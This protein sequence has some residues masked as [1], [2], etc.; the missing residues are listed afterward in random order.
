MSLATVRKIKSLMEDKNLK[1]KDI[2][3]FLNEP[4]GTVAK[5]LSENEK[6]RHEI[7]LSILIKLAPHLNAT[8][9]F[10]LGV[11]SSLSAIGTMTTKTIPLIGIAS[12]GIPDMVYNDDIQYIP[13]SEDIARDGVYAVTAE[14]DSMLSKIT[15]GDIVICDKEML[16]ESGNI[17]HYT[18]VDGESGIKKYSCDPE[19]E[20]VTLMPLNSD[21]TPVIKHSKDVKCARCF[22][23]MSD[24]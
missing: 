1:Q 21:Y 18:T 22:K 13:V 15:N 11:K 24:L 2:V 3:E 23:I 14:G 12:C 20:Q 4:Q 8:T 5:W 10:L 6:I 9:D 16:C 19:T 7:P 17:V